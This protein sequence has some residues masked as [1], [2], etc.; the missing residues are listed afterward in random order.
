MAGPSSSQL[1]NRLTAPRSGF[2][3]DE[4]LEVL[5]NGRHG[6]QSSVRQ[7]DEDMCSEIVH[8]EQRNEQDEK[9]GKSALGRIARSIQ[10]SDGNVWKAVLS[11]LTNAAS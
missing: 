4:D 10:V 6:S 2:D 1:Q 9:H 8:I 7:E 5:G 3:F 11:Q